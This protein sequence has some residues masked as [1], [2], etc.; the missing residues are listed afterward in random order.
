MESAVSVRWRRWVMKTAEKI[1]SRGRRDSSGC[2]T[3]TG[4]KTRS[5][6]RAEPYGVVYIRPPFSTKRKKFRVHQ[7]AYIAAHSQTNYGMNDVSFDISHLCHNSLCVEVAHLSR[8]P[9]S[10]NNHRKICKEEGRCYG[11]HGDYPSC[12]L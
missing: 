12:I 5:H 9:R 4:A 8:E 11:G 2:L 1:R 7:M 10:I 6:P 3:W